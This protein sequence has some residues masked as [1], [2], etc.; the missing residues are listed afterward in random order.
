MKKY[1][2]VTDGKVDGPRNL[3]EAMGLVEKGCAKYRFDNEEDY[4]ANLKKMNMADLQA[5]CVDHGIKPSSNR[6]QLI[7][8]LAKEFRQVTSTYKGAQKASAIS[9][10]KR[11]VAADIMKRLNG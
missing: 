9:G 4:V 11:A 6:P 1:N 8:R 3:Y 10:E 5:H 2:Y 7:Q